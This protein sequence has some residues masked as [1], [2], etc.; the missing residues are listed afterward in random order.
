ML[1]DHESLIS[2]CDTD[3]L[4]TEQ[5]HVRT[6]NPETLPESAGSKCQRNQKS[7]S[8]QPMKSGD[9]PRMWPL[10]TPKPACRVTKTVRR[11]NTFDSES[12]KCAGSQRQRLMNSW[13]FCGENGFGTERIRILRV[14]NRW[15]CSGD[16]SARRPFSPGLLISAGS[17]IMPGADFYRTRRRSC[18]PPIHAVFGVARG[19]DF[20]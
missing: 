4:P 11:V 8:T 15:Q 5:I 19:L 14:R 12:D 3:V 17:Q 2:T 18:S 10:R 1:P 16:L 9:P 13:G 7:G 6:E 20:P